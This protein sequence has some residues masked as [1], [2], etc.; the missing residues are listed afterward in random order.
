MDSDVV[1]IFTDTDLRRHKH[2]YRYPH[3]VQCR[4]YYKLSVREGVSVAAC[5]LC[6]SD[7]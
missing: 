3:K 1:N 6:E 4:M 5:R 7:R 2:T